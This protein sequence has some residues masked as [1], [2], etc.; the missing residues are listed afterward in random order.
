MEKSIIS[1]TRAVVAWCDDTDDMPHCLLG[2]SP[3]VYESYG[4]CETRSCSILCSSCSPQDPIDLHALVASV[5]C[6]DLPVD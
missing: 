3:A 4:Y 2:N 6:T 5:H 1:Y